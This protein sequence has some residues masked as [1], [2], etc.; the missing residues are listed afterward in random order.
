MSLARARLQ[1]ERK[2]WRKDHPHGFVAKP[3]SNTDGTQDLL[4]W[5]F[6]IP[7]KR[8]SVF[9]PAELSGMLTFTEDYP[10][11]PPAARFDKIDGEAPFHPNIFPDGKVCLS[12][13]NPPES[14]H[15]YGKGGTWTP[16][17]NVKHVLL[18]LQ[19][20]L[21]EATGYAAGREEAYRLYNNDRNAYNARVKRQVAK[22]MEA[23]R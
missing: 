22:R 5:S 20:S 14:R 13:I 17:L 1:E 7:A 3:M 23:L 11:F 2:A 8:D 19:K 10:H 18:A 12:I 6:I 9:S 15:A 16:A 21:D 4:H